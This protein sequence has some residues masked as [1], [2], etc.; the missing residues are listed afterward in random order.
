[1]RSDKKRASVKKR[2]TSTWLLIF[3]LLLPLWMWIGWL[4]QSAKPLNLLILDKTVPT[5]NRQEHRALAWVLTRQKFQKTG[6]GLYDINR[7]YFGFFPLKNEKY[8]I[9]DLEPF[10]STAIDSLSQHYQAAYFTDTYGV[11]TNEWYLHRNL[12]ERSQLIYGGTS[13]KDLLL[14]QRMKARG[15]L[16]LMEFNSIG[17]PTSGFV[18][19][20]VEKLFHFKWSGW[21]GRY[22]DTLDTLKNP[23]LPRWVVLL[24]KQQHGNLWPF[25]GSGIV[26][27][28]QNQTIE[29]LEEETD[30]VGKLP[31]IYRNKPLAASYGLPEKIPFAYWFDI[32]S[33]DDSNKVLARYR[34]DV[35]ARGDSLLRRHG[36]PT[37]WP[38]VIAH[39]GRYRFFYFAGDFCDNPIGLTMAHLR[40]IEYF[41]G[42]LYS[43][44]PLDRSRFFWHFYR[45][46]VTRVLNDYWQEQAAGSA[47]FRRSNWWKMLKQYLGISG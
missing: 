46:L 17:S 4:L 44:D 3:F 21:T 13:R 14:L 35:T 19:R 23:E 40:G 39:T 25:S 2:R 42:L 47:R 11:Y 20:G 7:D 15:K 1:M 16:I 37:D 27:V 6:D 30:L 10:D 26:F 32:I 5:H 12:T 34:I 8:R 9:H 31:M 43:R 41:R 45:P 28:H 18:R 22:F 38:A 33:T 36:I 29:I 24:Y